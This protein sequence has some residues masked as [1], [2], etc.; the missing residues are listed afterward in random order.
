MR[1][2]WLILSTGYITPK[3]SNNERLKGYTS[4]STAL[5]LRVLSLIKYKRGG[6]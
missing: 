4:I 1:N 6:K 5:L 3:L 2:S